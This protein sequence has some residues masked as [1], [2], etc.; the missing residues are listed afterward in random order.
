MAT[1]NGTSNG[2]RNGTEP[3]D[4]VLSRA[5]IVGIIERGAR[6]RL[7]ISARKLIASYRD[8]TLDDPG[9]VADLL[10]FARLLSRGDPLFARRR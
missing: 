10:G 1:R 2:V 7:G 4:H 9:E 5:E 8:G 6:K 3:T